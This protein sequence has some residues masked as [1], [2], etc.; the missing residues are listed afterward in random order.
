M[1]GEGAVG[2]GSRAGADQPRAGDRKTTHLGEQFERERSR[3][4]P[5]LELE[6]PGTHYAARSQLDGELAGCAGQELES[7]G[8]SIG[9]H[10]PRLGA[11]RAHSYV[12]GLRHRDAPG[13][14]YPYVQHRCRAP[15]GDERQRA[16]GNLEVRG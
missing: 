12:C 3:C 11:F 14:Q 9:I 15:I 16:S 4:I 2:V 8:R 7:H 1:R 13:V 5:R 6:F 10:A